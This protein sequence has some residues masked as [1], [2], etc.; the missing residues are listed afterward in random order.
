MGLPRYE[1]V[2]D[3]IEAGIGCG[4]LQAILEMSGSLR[5]VKIEA[6]PTQTG[7]DAEMFVH[8]IGKPT[9]VI[10]RLRVDEVREV[11]RSDRIREALK[12]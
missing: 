11:P 9:G 5:I 8:M 6:D 1:R 12:P 7:A 2:D 10:L 4:I 3:S